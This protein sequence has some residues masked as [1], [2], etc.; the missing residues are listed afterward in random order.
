MLIGLL[1]ESR[2]CQHHHRGSIVGYYLKMKL[3]KT[4]DLKVYQNLDAHLLVQDQNE[5][6][7]RDLSSKILGGVM[8]VLME[9]DA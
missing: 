8:L 7:I 2:F 6:I 3:T 9:Y 4:Y 1:I 5:E